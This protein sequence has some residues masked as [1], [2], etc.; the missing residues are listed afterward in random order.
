VEALREL[1]EA[2]DDGSFL[3]DDPSWDAIVK[4]RGV[5]RHAGGQ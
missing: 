4:A 3:P 5:L 2:L 1:V